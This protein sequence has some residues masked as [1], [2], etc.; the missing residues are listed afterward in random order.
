MKKITLSLLALAAFLNAETFTNTTYVEVINSEP[1][2]TTAQVKTPYQETVIRNYEV[3]VP[4]QGNHRRAD[5]NSIGL[6]TIIGTTLGIAV[7]NQIGKGNGKTAAKVIGGLG[8]G[9][10]ANQTRNAG[11]NRNCTQ[12]RQK[13]EIITRYETSSKRIIDYYINTFYFNGKKYKKRSTYNPLNNVPI[14]TVVS[15]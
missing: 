15:F 11:N 4:C 2:Y 3:N 12:I 1:V 13:K 10:M 5:T 14:K 6:D 9:Y 7:G 8:G